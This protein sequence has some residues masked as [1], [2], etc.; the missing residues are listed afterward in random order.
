MLRSPHGRNRGTGDA[1]LPSYAGN[2]CGGSSTKGREGRW[3][4]SITLLRDDALLRDNRCRARGR[5]PRS[6]S[7][8]AQQRRGCELSSRGACLEARKLKVIQTALNLAVASRCARAPQ[9]SSSG[10]A[11]TLPPPN[12]PRA[13]M[14]PRTVSSTTSSKARGCDSGGSSASLADDGSM[15][16]RGAARP[17][18]AQDHQYFGASIDTMAPNNGVRFNSLESQ[19][20]FL[21][22]ARRTVGSMRVGFQGL[23]F[24]VREHLPSKISNSRI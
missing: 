11:S 13:R 18:T 14:L 9:S 6:G 4:L 21:P 16:E 22:P 7:T 19:H 3:H 15:S 8:C 20:R 23:K 1:Y 10:T 2:Q 24:H 17:G 5:D 12:C